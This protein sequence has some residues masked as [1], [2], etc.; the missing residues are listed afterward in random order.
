MIFLRA[1]RQL[2]DPVDAHEARPEFDIEIVKAS[3]GQLI[4]GRCVCTS[5]N[6][7]RNT[8]NLKFINSGEVRTFHAP[9]IT[10]YNGKEVML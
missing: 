5:S 7:E 8:I 9:L 1:V 3:T 6:W 2:I 10:K 4:S